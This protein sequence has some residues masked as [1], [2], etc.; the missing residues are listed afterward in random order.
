MTRSLS[1]GDPIKKGPA[2][3]NLLSMNMANIYQDTA[4]TEIIK[5][6]HQ[7]SIIFGKFLIDHKDLIDNFYKSFELQGHHYTL[8]QPMLSSLLLIGFLA[9]HKLF[10]VAEMEK[11]YI[12]SYFKDIGMGLL[13]QDKFEGKNPNP[14]DKSQISQHAE[15]SVDL[16]R[17]R[18]PLEEDQLNLIAHHHDIINN[19][20]LDEITFGFESLI[21]SVTDVITAMLSERPYRGRRSLY[22]TL[23][24][25]KHIF[26]DEYFSEFKLLVH[27][28]RNFFK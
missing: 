4:N 17:G 15:K 14:D 5:M 25:L 28:L 10:S 11:L 6:Q 7:S 12:T 23:E 27:Y 2:Q 21:V 13:P 8:A 3:M 16:L 26:G 1:T 9:K 20:N 24:Y 19:P 18:I 22:E